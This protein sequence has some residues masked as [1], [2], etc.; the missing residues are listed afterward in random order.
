MNKALPD[1]LF[2]SF[3]A[4]ARRNFDTTKV[5]SDPDEVAMM[6]D[7]AQKVIIV[8]GYGMAYTVSTPS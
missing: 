8:P 2:K 4:V 7:G 3:E 1:V 6:L 5:G